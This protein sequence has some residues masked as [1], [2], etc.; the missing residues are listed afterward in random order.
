MVSSKIRFEPLVEPERQEWFMAGTEQAISRLADPRERPPR[1]HSPA[2]GLIIALDPDIPAHH[3][4]LLFAAQGD[5][6]MLNWMLDGRA[7]GQA[8][9]L[10]WPPTPGN[11]L[12]LTGPDNKAYDQVSFQVRGRVR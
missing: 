11:H 3:Q 2:D 10:L 6:E 5:R 1:I 9:T 4:A 8:N 7:L 12:L